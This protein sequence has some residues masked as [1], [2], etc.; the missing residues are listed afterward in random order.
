MSEDILD[1]IANARATENYNRIKKGRYEWIVERFYMEKKRNGMCLIP[2]LRVVSSVKTDPN[3]DPDPVGTTV[4]TAW[5][6][7]TQ[8]DSAPGNVKAFI[9][10][11]AGLDQSALTPAQVKDLTNE[12]ISAAQPFR[13]MRVNGETVT[14]INQG[15]KNPN[16]RGQEMVIPNF[17][18]VPG[19][20]AE[21]VAK[22][23]AALDG[24]QPATPPAPVQAPPVSAPQ[25]SGFNLSSIL[26]R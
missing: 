15:K 8:P 11:V 25:P 12:A 6:I 16:N 20:T 19:Q 21:S 5:N 22:N 18:H 23:R 4:S 14:R 7:T 2:E 26:P 10:A 9:L 1:R 3:E 17:K 24:G 13:G